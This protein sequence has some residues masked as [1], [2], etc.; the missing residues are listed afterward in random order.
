MKT[1]RYTGRNM[2]GVLKKGVIQADTQGKAI[3]LLRTKGIN[4]REILESNSIF[5]KNITLFESV[6][7]QDF[8]IFCRQFAT[9]VRAGVSIVE[10][11]GILAAQTPSKL[12]KNSLFAVE[13]DIREGIPFSDAANKHK[14]VFPPLF[15]NM[16]RAGELTGSLDETLERLAAYYE[17]QFTLKKKV[18]ST[19]MYPAVLLVVIVI[20]VIGLMLTVVP[21]FATM[22]ED[23]GAELPAITL[24]VLALSDLIQQFWWLGLLLVIGLVVTFVYI[25]KNNSLFNYN[26]NLILLRV[27]VF[28]KLLQKS[29]IARMTRTLSSLFSSSVPILQALTIVE[30][31]VGN[32]VVG[33][34]VLDSRTS[35]EQGGTLSEPLRKSWIFPPLVHQMTAIGE[36]TGSLDYMLEKIADFYE[37]DV[38]RT[39]DTLKGLIEPLM[40]VILA[41]VVG[42]IVLSIMVP[43]FSLFEQI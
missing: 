19:M 36:K 6:K 31:V 24:F 21:Q 32:P 13:A 20:V 30:K 27:P 18:Q 37:A 40:I 16:I 43:M 7:N 29:A 23:F 3:E 14:K 10:S 17:K 38:D 5:H 39:V 42:M 25:Y 2:E 8:V 33:K 4:P 35:L 34:V 9:L 41:G 1:F 15:V 26:V 12:L 22:F 11:T 28:G